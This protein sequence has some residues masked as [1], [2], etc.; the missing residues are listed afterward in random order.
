MTRW[1]L[2]ALMIL[3]GAGVLLYV[4]VGHRRLP[5]RPAA[6]DSASPLIADASA[7]QKARTATAKTSS[8]AEGTEQP[9]VS[10]A[11]TATARSIP[12]AP[13]VAPAVPE[14]PESVSL[15]PMTILENMRTAIRNYGSS[16]GGNPVG[17]NAEITSAL[18]GENP[19]QI[20]FLKPDGNRVNANGELVDPW[21][22]PYFF[23]QISG[24]ETEIRSAGPDR[25]MYTA[26][27]LVT[28]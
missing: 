5:V 16:L 11:T 27:D 25:V 15:P 22:T 18:Q 7:A 12:P 17:N 2:V 3:I 8:L 4:E 14:T 21:G 19:K 20:N 9:A 24:Q 23:H 28:R 13:I 26:D 6:A 1:R 10:E